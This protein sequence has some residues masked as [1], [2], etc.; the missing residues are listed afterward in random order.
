MAERSVRCEDLEFNKNIEER[1]EI[2]KA[3]LGEGGTAVFS[4]FGAYLSACWLVFLCFLG[5]Y[6]QQCTSMQVLDVNWQQWDTKYHRMM[7][8]FS[9]SSTPST[10]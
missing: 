6:I 3:K 4:C 9:D 8:M 10:V 5:I 2:E 7:R 1:Y